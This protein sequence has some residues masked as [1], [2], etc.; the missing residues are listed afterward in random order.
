MRAGAFLTNACLALFFHAQETIVLMFILR[1]AHG[2]QLIHISEPLLRK[3]ER[4]GLAVLLVKGKA[5]PAILLELHSP[6]P[7]E[8]L[9]HESF[10]AVRQV[11]N[12]MEEITHVPLNH[13]SQA[14]AIINSDKAL[15]HLKIY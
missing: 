3:S 4:S 11:L 1:Q 12:R 13:L 2:E 10:P 6:E 15:C 9:A 8:G 5:A 14:G 7:A